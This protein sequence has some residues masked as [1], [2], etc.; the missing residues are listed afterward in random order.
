[1]DTLKNKKAIGIIAI[2]LGLL[3]FTSGINL[4][5]ELILLKDEIE[6]YT[7]PIYVDISNYISTIEII[8]PF[9]IILVLGIFIL[10]IVLLNVDKG[11]PQSEPRKK[12]RQINTYLL[13]VTAIYALF[14][15]IS[16]AVAPEI[17]SSQL[18]GWSIVGSLGFVAVLILL[19]IVGFVSVDNES[20]LQE[21]THI[22]KTDFEKNS[23][24]KRECEAGVFLKIN[25]DNKATETVI[26]DKNENIEICS[27]CGCQIF[28]EETK[29]NNCGKER[30]IMK[31]T[32]T[33]KAKKVLPSNNTEQVNIQLNEKSNKEKLLEI[34]DLYK[35]KLITEKE[36]EE[37][38]KMIIEGL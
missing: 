18:S 11:I 27:E 37:K 14:E 12:S 5:T 2:I 17:L 8:L 35:E 25:D 32:T 36:Y 38:R 31:K 4:I 33:N 34:K 1:M 23:E 26:S 28:P 29:C 22:Q 16:I 19:C 24:V 9:M 13:I 15:I 7:G 30:E 6:G 20:N 21:E 10:G 3:R